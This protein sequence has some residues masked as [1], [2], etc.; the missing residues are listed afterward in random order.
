MK[1]LRG[2]ETT[3]RIGVSRSGLY[4]QIATGCFTRPVKT[5]LRSSGW[6]E[7]EVDLIAAARAAGVS[8]DEIKLLV[9]MLHE[10]RQ[11]RYRELLSDIPGGDPCAAG[12][13]DSLGGGSGVSK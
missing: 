9:E 4:E 10:A 7:H 3:S 8:I 12:H 5:G 6:P 1:I 11:M 13:Y 2:A